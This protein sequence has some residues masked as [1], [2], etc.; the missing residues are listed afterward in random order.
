MPRIYL[1]PNSPEFA[2]PD[3][4]PKSRGCDM[5]GCKAGGEHRAPK[6]RELTDYYWFCYDHAREYNQAWN[7][8]SGMAGE[9]VENMMARS[10]Y[11]DRPTW[12]Y[13]IPGAAEELRRKAWKTYNFTDE[14]PPRQNKRQIQPTTPEGEA[15][16][17]MGLTAP[18]T[19]DEI[20][21]R[22]KTLAKQFH[23]DLNREDPKAE[24][25]LKSINMAYTILKISYDKF[26]ALPDT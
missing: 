5:P 12:R 23:P 4:K 22:Y 25:T 17:I 2:D 1:K 21:T 10:F 16:A 7:Y 20:K 13:D 18:V 14:E 8:F 6:N 26:K 11:G 19:L 15:L 24:D 3:E 9:D